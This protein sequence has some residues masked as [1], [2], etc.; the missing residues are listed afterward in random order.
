[1]KLIVIT[2]VTAFEKD[3]KSL[4]IK[5]KI[6]QFSYQNVIGY[7][8]ATLDAVGN[9]WFGAEM[10]EAESILFYAF[11]PARQLE[12]LFDEVKAYNAQQ[13]AKSKVHLSV[14][15]IEKTSDHD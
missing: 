3:I 12:M 10:N 11:V 14:L 15:N 9:N 13:E 6:P 1:M 4:L 2:A 7:R 8:D 5:S